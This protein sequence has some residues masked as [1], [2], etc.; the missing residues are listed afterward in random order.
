MLPKCGRTKSHRVGILKIAL[1]FNQSR[2]SQSGSG[3]KCP[4]FLFSHTCIFFCGTPLTKYNRESEGTGALLTYNN[5]HK[6]TSWGSQPG[7]KEWRSRRTSGKYLSQRGSQPSM[8]HRLGSLE[9]DSV[10]VTCRRFKKYSQKIHLEGS[11]GDRTGTWR[12]WLP[13]QLKPEVSA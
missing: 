9:T 12:S 1:T 13:M 7:G 3:N 6:W 8:C 4:T 2:P 10:R 11:E 5:S